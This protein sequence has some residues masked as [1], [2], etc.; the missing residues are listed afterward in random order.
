MAGRF[1][2]FGFTTLIP[3]VL[4][5]ILDQHDFGT[6]KQVLLLSTSLYF[7]AQLGVATSLFYFLPKAGE[8]AGRY[9][10]NACLFLGAAG[11]ACTLALGLG[12]FAVARWLNNPGL[13]EHL[14]A[15][16]AYTALVVATVVFEVAMTCRGQYRRAALTFAVTDS[17]RA[18]GFVVPV[19]L[20]LGVHGLLLGGIAVGAC[21]LAAMIAYFRREYGAALA[22]DSRLFG[23]QLAYAIPFGAAVFLE[24]VVTNLHQY[25]VSHR[26]D[27]A[28]FAIYAAGCLQIPFVDFVAVPAGD[29]MMVKMREALAKGV[30]GTAL[31]I[32]HDTTRKLALLFFPVAGLSLVAAQPLIL[33]LYTPAYEASAPIFMVFSM[34]SVL[35]AILVDGVMRVHAQTR[36]L[37]FNN[38][39]RLGVTLALIGPFIGGFG[40]AGAVAVTLCA[41]AVAKLANLYRMRRLMAITWG[42]VLPWGGLGAILLAAAAA[43]LPA[44][45]VR[46]G[47]ADRP[48]FALIAAAATYTLAYVISL[49]GMGVLNMSERLALSAFLQKLRAR[50]GETA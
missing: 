36:F 13:A 47:F 31:L 40:L 2:A 30:A 16:G 5:R 14:P 12:R 34:A 10:C 43:T 39:V 27:A 23:A 25:V 48:A 49:F 38:L 11:L 6:Y 4:V 29:V 9:L 21:R 15:T 45:L 44:L 41:T 35:S 26:F 37:F 8:N 46:D 24:I 3:L 42:Q 50:L 18:A 32:W 20:G 1:V 19:L 7:V 33:V 22:P 28:A 17:L